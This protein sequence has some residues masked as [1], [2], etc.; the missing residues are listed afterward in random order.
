MMRRVSI[1]VKYVKRVLLNGFRF[2]LLVRLRSK[3]KR[4]ENSI[5]ENSITDD[6][7]SQHFCEIPKGCITK[8]LSFC[9]AFAIENQKQKI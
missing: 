1:F 7:K 4:Y 5:Y 3:S 8:W 9:F 2:V 6:E